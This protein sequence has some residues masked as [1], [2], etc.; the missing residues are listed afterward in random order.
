[1]T[2]A[3][4]RF[5]GVDGSP[6]AEVPRKEFVNAV[7]RMVGNACEDVRQI[8]FRIDPVQFRR[9]DQAVYGCGAIAAS[10]RSSKQI[11]LAAERI[12]DSKG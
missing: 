11:V 9:A 12:S 3:L 8:G 5:V 7:D 1:M 4:A 6:K 2:A 10:I